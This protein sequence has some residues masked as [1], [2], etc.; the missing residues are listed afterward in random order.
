MTGPVARYLLLLAGVQQIV[1]P[2]LL[3]ADGFGGDF[4]GPQVDTAAEPAGYAFAIWGPIYLGCLAFSIVQLLPRIRHLP[5]LARIRLPAILL[6]A[7]STIWLAAAR[8]GPS[9]ATVPIIWGML[10]AALACFVPLARTRP[11]AP[12]L[13]FAGLWPFGL[14]AGWLTAAAFVNSASILPAVGVGGLGLGADPIA[15]V[16]VAG[17]ALVALAV[18]RTCAGALP[19]AVAVAWALVGIM[20]ANRAP[21]GAAI[22][23]WAAVA[24][25]PALIIGALAIRR[26]AA[27]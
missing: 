23:L 16:M 8:F 17:T 15:V 27:P 26:H 3:F 10:A 11:L 7:G 14:Y 4:A 12:L 19:Y 1:A 13:R 18:L 22:V 2:G 20:V 9:W 5:P 21:D 24:A 6:F 25:L